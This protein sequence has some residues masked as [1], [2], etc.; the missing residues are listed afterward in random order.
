MDGLRI[1]GAHGG[2]GNKGMATTCLQVSKHIVIDAGNILEALGEEALHVDHIFFTHSHLDHVIDGAF[3]VDNF[4]AKRT[5]PL[6]FYGL[7]KTLDAI[8]E[9]LFN[10]EIWPDFS[11]LE[12]VQTQAPA[13]EFVPVMPN[14]TYEVEGYALKPILANHTVPC[15]GYEVTKDGQGI[16]FTSDTTDHEGLWTYLNEALHV[17]AFIVDVSFPNALEKV[18][19]ASKHFSPRALAQGL[20]KLTRKDVLCYVYHLKPSYAVEVEKE[21]ASFPIEAILKGQEV[22][23]YATG[24]LVPQ[25]EVTDKVKSLNRIGAALSAQNQI[26][27]LLEM[28]VEEAKK[29]THADAGTLYLLQDN[30]LYFKVVQTDSLGIRMGGLSDPI[31]WPPLPLYQADGTP[32]TTMVAVTC[33]L[34]G[35]PICIPDVYEAEGFNF[36]GTKRFDA[37]TGY[38]SR[39]MLVLP[40]RNHEG[41]II[42]VLQ[43]LNKHQQEEGGVFN[44]EDSEIG[45]SLASQAAVALTN[46]MLI[47]D[48]EALLEGFLKSIIYAIKMKSPHT[49][50]HIER[51]VEISMMFARKIHQDTQVFPS[52]AYTHQG[53]KELH[54]AALMHDIGKLATPEYVLDKAT[55]LEGIFDR[56]AL[57]RE[58][59]KNIQLHCEIACLKGEIT[60]DEKEAKIQECEEILTRLEQTNLGAEFVPD[61]H[62]EAIRQLAK[63]PFRVGERSFMVL[64]SCEAEHLSVQKGTL[65]Q[66]E[67][68]IIN[69]HAKITLDILTQLPFPKKYK[70]VPQISANHHEKISGKGYP[71]GLKG[72]EISFEARL[73]AI[74]DIFEAL[75]AADRP[76][77][78]A[79][80]LSSA[81][82]I[83]YFMAKDD[84]LDRGLVKFFYTSGLY[85]E[86][87][88]L[89]LPSHLIDEVKVD[90]EAL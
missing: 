20:E 57:V 81:M 90:F 67:R 36:E 17:R 28:I 21:L 44:K 27:T 46:T 54:F 25:E 6:R 37:N 3:L 80:T 63:E 26:D 56:I 23:A 88:K 70:E 47:E 31:T 32:N 22:I 60:S 73:L 19:H 5:K 30:A 9:H 33:A 39:S 58:R 40:L 71:Q 51:M 77:K 35:A 29:I 53:F 68:D 64:S 78:K 42:G 76:Y 50:G 49:A 2:R 11:S 13:V 38:R 72:D 62:V 8:K 74:A 10:G 89:H 1:L 87:A 4:F 83:L 24:E 61:A 48:L 14:E 43:L 7:Q 55:K 85:L 34:E 15:C 69:H 41:E 86:Y 75:T 16:F 66:E 12:L 52:K 59:I 84:E 18:A 65:T 45:L 79:N 82:K